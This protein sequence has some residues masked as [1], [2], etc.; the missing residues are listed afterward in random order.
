MCLINDGIKDTEHF[1]LKCHAYDGRRRNLLGAIN[2]ILWLHNIPNMPNQTFVRI[3]LFGD[4]RF[5]HHQNRQILESMLKFI[6]ASERF[7]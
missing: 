6:H 2:E 3:M 1:L 5:A 7:L 4:N